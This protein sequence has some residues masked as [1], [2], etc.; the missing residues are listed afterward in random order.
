MT[1]G[2]PVPAANDEGVPGPVPGAPVAAAAGADGWPGP[3]HADWQDWLTTSLVRGASDQALLDGMVR[4][5]FDPGHARSTISVLR[6]MTTRV[7]QQHP[8]V[9]DEFVSDPIRLPEGARVRVADREVRIGMV[10]SNP[11]IALIDNLLSEQECDKLI[12]FAQGKLR[13][14]EVVDPNSGRL[15]ISGVRSSEGAHFAYGENAIVARIEARVAALT[16]LPVT[17]G[18]PLQLLHYP[19]GGEYVPHHDYFDPAF[20]GAAVQM[21]AGGQRLATIVMYLREPEEGGGTYFPELELLVRPPRG[22]AV[23]FEYA[24]AAGRL[25]SRCLHAG[26]PVVRGHKW[27]ATKWLRQ[28]PYVSP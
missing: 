14:S 28:G 8:S 22:G 21:R 19:V 9:L 4:A 24:N 23:Y 18:E 20:E 15:E 12:Q 1:A 11:N 16:R 5:G 2:L 17:H 26:L 3:L 7:Q 13:R 27:I 10:L 25:D 6:S